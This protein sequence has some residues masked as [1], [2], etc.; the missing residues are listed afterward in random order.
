MSVTTAPPASG[1]RGKRSGGRRVLRGLGWT[2]IVCGVLVLLFV[3]YQLFVTN[4]ITDRIQD[5]LRRDFLGQVQGGET[6]QG[7]AGQQPIPGEAAGIIRIPDIGLNMVFVE[8]V[9]PEHLKRG[10]G[11]Y[12]ATPMPGEGG[13]VGIAGHRTTYSKPFWALDELAP[14][15]RIIA[16]TREGR[17]VYEVTWTEVVGPDRTGVLD[18]VPPGAQASEPLACAEEECITLTT[19]HPRFSAAQRLIVRGVLVHAGPGEGVA[20]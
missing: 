17:F 8:G 1:V 4:V 9:T 16:R 15:D 10:P 5:G 6:S 11:H 20:R 7:A 13:N 19:C 18:K 12:P 2:L 14:G 3:V